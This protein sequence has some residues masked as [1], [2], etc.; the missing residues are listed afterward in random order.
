[1]EARQYKELALIQRISVCN[2]QFFQ[3][4]NERYMAMIYKEASELPPK[5][6]DP[7]DEVP[8]TEAMDAGDPSVKNMLTSYA[9]K[10]RVNARSRV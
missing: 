3:L 1:M 6:F 9:Q 2:D 5:P 7:R 8:K 10:L 4:M